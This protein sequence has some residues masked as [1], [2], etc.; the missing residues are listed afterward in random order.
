MSD[1]QLL[2]II[3]ELVFQVTGVRTLTMDTD[4]VQD[5][6]LNSLD[7][8]NL[9]CAFEERFDVQIPLKSVWELKQV[10]DV[11]EFIH[12]EESEHTRIIE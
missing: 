2:E 3:E 4:F 1:G 8:A 12:K 6:A 10:K 11:I 5:L 9:V 7:V